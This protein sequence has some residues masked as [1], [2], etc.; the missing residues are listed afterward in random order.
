VE[1]AASIPVG[2]MTPTIAMYNTGS[3]SFG[4]TPPWTARGRNKYAGKPFIVFSAAS[5]VGQYG[6]HS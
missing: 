4:L 5:S 6:E 3:Q 2:L 1:E